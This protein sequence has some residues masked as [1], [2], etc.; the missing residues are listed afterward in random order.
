M[1]SSFRS[2]AFRR[3]LYLVTPAASSMMLRRS[4]A[5]AETM[6]PTRPCSMML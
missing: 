5:L 3:D 1:A 4:S 6:S 2:A